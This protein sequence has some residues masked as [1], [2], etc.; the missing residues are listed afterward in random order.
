MKKRL[1]ILVFLFI[2]SQGLS[3]T[4]F[5]S[6]SIF[7]QGAFDEASQ[8]IHP[9]EVHKDMG[10]Q[11]IKTCT[12]FDQREILSRF[13]K[14]A[15]ITY[16]P[17]KSSFL[18]LERAEDGQGLFTHFRHKKLLNPSSSKIYAKFYLW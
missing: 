9:S 2:C 10:H 15:D 14:G 16:R 7:D 13:Y 1:L 5:D 8:K 4:A 12:L 11:K 18:S 17:V 3:L 6:P